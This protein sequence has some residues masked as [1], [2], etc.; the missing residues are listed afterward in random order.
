MVDNVSSATRSKIMRAIKST[1]TKPER[2]VRRVVR[3]LGVGYRLKSPKLPG[4]PDLIFPG[5]RKVI[6]VNGCFWHAHFR[7]AIFC[8][9]AREPSGDYWKERLALNAGRDERVI[10]E[11][12][13]IGWSALV[14][15]ECQLG[16]IF[17]VRNTI[18]EFLRNEEQPHEA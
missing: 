14:I 2:I 4:K 16:D 8:R 9:L 3:E 12:R 15:W 7:S 18:L 17:A 5:R 11:L 13:Q 6:F 10:A 1:G